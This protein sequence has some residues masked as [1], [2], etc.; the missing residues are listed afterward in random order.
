MLKQ[1]NEYIAGLSNRTKYFIL[2]VFFLGGIGILFQTLFPDRKPIVSSISPNNET[3]V[4]ENS[5]FT[6]SFSTL[7][8]DKTKK[9][10]TFQTNPVISAKSY[11]LDNNYQYYFQLTELMKN[12]TD[13]TIQV[14]YK[15]TEIFSHSF[16]TAEFSLEEMQAQLIEQSKYEHEFGQAVREQI[17]EFP[18]YQK[19]PIE[20]DQFIIV[21]DYKLKSFRINLLIPENTNEEIKQNLQKK[22]LTAL[23]EINVDPVEWNYH[24]TYQN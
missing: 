17:Q 24:F 18:W 10:L 16:K 23:Q 3:N 2:F 20:T 9:S 5:S 19:I 6:L 12:N 7:L 11:W 13:Y 8:D 15:D 22:A 4:P 14:F 1:I 21:Y